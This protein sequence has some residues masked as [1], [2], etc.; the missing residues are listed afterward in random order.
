MNISYEWLPSGLVQNNSK[1]LKEC[2]DLYSNHYGK[3]SDNAPDNAGKKIKL[4]SNRILEWL[5][6][7]ASAIYLARD[8]NDLVGYAIALR[9]KVLRYG[10]ISWVTQ[11]VVHEKYRHQDIAKNI[12][13]SVWGLTTDTA[14]G[15]ISAN[16]YAIRALEKA[17]RR[18]SDPE[19]IKQN[20]QRIKT[21]GIAN[22]SYINKETP[23]L[24]AKEV[25]KI[26][27]KFYVDHSSIDQMLE[28]VTSMEVPW[29]L[30]ELE[31]GWEWLAFTFRDQIPIELDESELK[32][33]LEAS[34]K[35]VQDAYKRMDLTNNHKWSQNTDYEVNFILQECEL[36]KND[37]VIDF[38]CG[39]G[40]H[41][42]GLAQKDIYVH[43]I[44][45]IEKNI[46]AA[47]KKKEENALQNAVFYTDDCRTI[48]LENVK[49]DA[50]ICL[51]DV[52]GTYADNNENYKILK[53]IYAH[54]KIGG[55]ALISVMNFELT[56]FNAKHRFSLKSN[57]S[58]LLDIKPSN[59]M[60]TTG[61]I[62]NPDFYWIE[63]D[64]K[65][66][67]RKEQFTRGTS[68]PVELFVRDKRFT[69]NEII[70][71]CVTIGF[72]IIYTRYVNAGDW[73]TDYS[74]TQD[75]AKE[76]LVKCRRIN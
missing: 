26:N 33:L 15:I 6:N 61:N 10:V 54:L 14:W 38:G 75:S 60:E 20:I 56:D 46:K 28:N 68:L 36:R 18:R 48:R 19:K 53:N 11:L 39:I 72:E 7:E 17:T 76:I 25:S 59:I 52:I 21:I 16:P 4:S 24:V 27:T 31:E 70:E 43:G 12:L 63:E 23:Y 69:K 50:V 5:S 32:K 30:G 64:T 41:A 40:R 65:I 9:L 3:W 67:Y 1:L 22:V 13:Y 45:Y 57:P 66:V 2:S 71:M 37:T 8:N 29:K 34:D 42:I 51:Y 49:A 73:E 35:V 55:I 62:F 47:N 58:E 74:P 44:D